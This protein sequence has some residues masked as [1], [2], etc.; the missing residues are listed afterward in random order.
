LVL[1]PLLKQMELFSRLLEVI[2]FFRQLLLLAGAAETITRT[3]TVTATGRLLEVL[4]G[5]AH[6]LTTPMDLVLLGKDMTAAP[7]I[8]GMRQAVVVAQAQ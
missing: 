3:T 4:V 8:T 7:K 2:P 5:A 6:V 1:E